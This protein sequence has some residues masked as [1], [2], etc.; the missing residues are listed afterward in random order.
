MPTTHTVQQGEC[1][2]RIAQAYGFRDYTAIYN[3]PDNGS[4]RNK[5]PNPN[6]LLPGDQVLIPDKA[7]SEHAVPT[8]RAHRFVV[9]SPRRK[10]NLIFQDDTGEP[11]AEVAYR[12]TAAQFQRDGK[13]EVDGSIRL[14][15]PAD[16]DWVDVEMFSTKRRFHIGRLDPHWDTASDAAVISGIQAR[17]RNLGYD[18]GPADGLLGPRTRRAIRLYEQQ[19]DMT[20]TGEPGKVV[21][22]KLASD[23][24]C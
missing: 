4:L 9:K 16:V 5:R 18:A 12:L 17:L 13:T 19:N 6:I 1:L 22:S 7:P 23:H 10:L 11:L 14:A 24:G 15:L 3:H 8:G 21:A 2:S 20:V